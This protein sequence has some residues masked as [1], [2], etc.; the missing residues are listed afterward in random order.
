MK[1][2][3]LRLMAMPLRH[4]WRVGLVALLVSGL[5]ITM[6]ARVVWASTV[7]VRGTVV[8]GPSSEPLVPIPILAWPE[9]RVGSNNLSTKV[10]ARIY[11]SLG[12][13]MQR[14][15]I[16]TT[17]GTGSYA[18]IN[19]SSL[20]PDYYDIFI[21]GESHLTRKLDNYVLHA[22]L[23]EID[24][25]QSSTTYL[26]SGDINGTEF[27]DDV[28]NSIDLS[29]LITDLDA[30]DLRSDLNRDNLVNALDLSALLT[31]LDETGET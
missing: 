24:G 31:N 5:L 19:I 17:S 25:T 21:K 1:N 20:S 16:V 3:L 23:P 18:N 8:V 15:D 9:K 11:D 30:F 13:T 2:A 22:Y 27:G 7:Y 29:I 28:V 10:R 26:L 14:E 12:D 6:G 4:Q